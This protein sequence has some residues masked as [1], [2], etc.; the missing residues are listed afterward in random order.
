[1]PLLTTQF[2][3]ECLPSMPLVVEAA[4]LVTETFDSV[5]ALQ[6]GVE[7]YLGYHGR[8]SLNSWSGSFLCLLYMK[9]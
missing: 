6:G 5:Q 7:R 1:M 8:Q 2:K 4:A 3:G 9:G